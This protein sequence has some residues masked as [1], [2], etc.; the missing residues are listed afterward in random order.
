MK[1]VTL[2]VADLDRWVRG[3]GVDNRAKKNIEK[4]SCFYF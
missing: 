1:T 3:G 2:S 4:T